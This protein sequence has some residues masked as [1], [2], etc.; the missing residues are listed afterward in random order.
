[1]VKKKKQS[2][3]NKERRWVDS[4]ARPS[5]IICEVSVL[6]G[7]LSGDVDYVVYGSI[8][9]ECDLEGTLILQ[10]PGQWKG[11]ILAGNIVISGTVHGDVR[12]KNKLELTPTAR[13]T[14]DITGNTVAIAEGAIFEG[15]ISMTREDDVSYFEDR[16]AGKEK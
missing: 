12:A 15:N 1:M 10:K 5:S 11:D 8:E 9:G 7:K 14:G 6:A 16:R 13:I 3:D 2:D 4:V